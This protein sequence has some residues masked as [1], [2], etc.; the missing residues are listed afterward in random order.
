MQDIRRIVDKKILLCSSNHAKTN[1][2]NAL[3]TDNS[4]DSNPISSLQRVT[5]I[6]V[7]AFNTSSTL[8]HYLVENPQITLSDDDDFEPGPRY[9]AFPVGSL[10][11]QRKALSLA[12]RRRVI[13][14]SSSDEQVRANSPLRES[15]THQ[16]RV[17]AID[18]PMPM[19]VNC[20][21]IRLPS[22]VLLPLLLRHRT[23][24]APWKKLMNL[25][26]SL[27]K[28]KKRCQQI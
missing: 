16:A 25:R 20:G 18:N 11:S 22:R 10:V 12:R 3:P 28:V 1:I 13:P 24:S 9:T 15:S 19:K 4:S 2:N 23:L 21:L 7:P 27:P 6:T 5:R 26:P 8:T 14:A 17:L